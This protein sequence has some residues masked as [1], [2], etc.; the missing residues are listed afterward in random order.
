M[1][2]PSAHI[3]DVVREWPGPVRGDRLP[4][5][6]TGEQ[7]QRATDNEAEQGRRER[8]SSNGR[9]CEIR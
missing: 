3:Q 2:R 8:Q 5:S 6:A 7:G 4:S 9:H 1:Q